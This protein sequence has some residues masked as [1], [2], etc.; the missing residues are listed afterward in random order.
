MVRMD[1]I[2]IATNYIIPSISLI[3]S[4][5][6]IYLYKKYKTNEV[7]LKKTYERMID[8]SKEKERV[9]S[10]FD[11]GEITIFK[12]INDP[13]WSVEYV[14]RSVSTIFGYGRNQFLKGEIKY[15]NIIYKDD[16]NYVSFEIAEAIK[17]GKN[18][19]SSTI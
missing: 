8:E 15:S 5:V 13:N 1:F 17:N 9:L 7:L 4:S 11:A 2:T 3:S 18:F 16:L 10:L 14:S 6:A 19:Y 12:W